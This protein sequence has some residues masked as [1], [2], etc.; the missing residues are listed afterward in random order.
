MWV[1]T[2]LEREANDHTN[3]IIMRIYMYTYA[4]AIVRFVS[5]L[6]TH[7]LTHLYN[8]SLRTPHYRHTHTRTLGDCQ[9]N[10]G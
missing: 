6:C 2:Q 4:W 8:G 7:I 3:I 5:N 1:I 10:N 9:M